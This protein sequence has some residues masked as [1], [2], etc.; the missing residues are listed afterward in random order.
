M[1]C[2]LFFFEPRSHSDT[3]LHGEGSPCASLVSPCLRG[4]ITIGSIASTLPK[5]LFRNRRQ[6]EFT[7]HPGMS[8]FRDKP[9][10]LDFLFIQH[11]E[12]CCVDRIQTIVF[13]HSYP[14]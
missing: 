8:T 5:N 12:I 4:S 13:P 2:L 9:F 10:M 14:E 11:F 1:Y 3:V 6:V 7:I